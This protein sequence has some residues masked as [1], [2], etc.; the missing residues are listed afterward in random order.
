MALEAQGGL[1]DFLLT[2]CQI[3]FQD[4]GPENLAN[5]TLPI[6]PEPEAIVDKDSA[7][8]S[9]AVVALEAPF[10]TP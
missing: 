1:Y 10:R 4:V 3:L 2:C 6:L 7:Y 9:I 8:A 5:E